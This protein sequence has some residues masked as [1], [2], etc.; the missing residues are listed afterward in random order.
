MSQ[1]IMKILVYSFC[2]VA[3]LK[4]T[5]SYWFF[6]FWQQMFSYSAFLY[7]ASCVTHSQESLMKMTAE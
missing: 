4:D 5:S 2:L 3:F 1:L 6:H 7:S